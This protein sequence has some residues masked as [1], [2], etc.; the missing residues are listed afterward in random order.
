MACTCLTFGALDGGQ[1]GCLRSATGLLTLWGYSNLD[2]VPGTTEVQAT[3]GPSLP[4]VCGGHARGLEGIALH[5]TVN[6]GTIELEAITEV[7]P[8]LRLLS[9]FENEACSVQTCQIV[10]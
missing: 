8:H 3:T 9:G 1:T 5:G 7:A 2:L 10:R 4:S 6:G